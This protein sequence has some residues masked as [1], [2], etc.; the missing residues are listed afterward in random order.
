MNELVRVSLQDDVAVITI[1]NPPVNALSTP[2]A[3]SLA[4]AVRE[5][6]ANDSVRAIVVIGSGNTFVAG[7]DIRELAEI[8]AGQAPRLN[9]LSPLQTVED[10]RKPVVMAIHG[11]AL[12]GGLEAAMSGHYRLAIPSAQFAMPEVKLGLIPGA[13]G[14]QRLPRLV[15]PAR[16]VEMCLEGRSIGAPAALEYGLVDRIV[17]GDLLDEAVSF[18]RE[19]AHL[20]PPKTS[21]REGRLVSLEPGKLDAFRARI[22][23]ERPSKAPSAVLEAI[24]ASTELPFEAGCKRE[25][26]LFNDCLQSGESKALIHIFFGERA[27]AKIPALAITGK[28]FE[29][30][31]VAVIGAGTM[32]TGIAT[33]F[34]QAGIPVLLKELSD[35]ALS[36]GMANV[37]ANFERAVAKGRLTSEVGQSR[38]AGVRAQTDYCG[39]DEVDLAVEAVF[40]DLPVKQ[41]VMAELGKVVRADCILATNTSSLDVDAI[42]AG[43]GSLRRTI[44]L[45]FFSP[46]NVMRLLEVVPGTE[47]GPDVTAACMSLGKRLGKIAVC[48]RNRPGFI[49]NRVFR[50]YLREARLLVEEGALVEEVNDALVGFGM[51]MGPLAVDDLIGIDVSRHIEEEFSRSDRPGTRKSVLLEALYTSGNF[52]QKSGKGWAEYGSDRKPRPNPDID[53]LAAEAA[54][55]IGLNRRSITQ[56]EIV[57]RCVC[58]LVNEGA[59]ILEEGTAFRASDI[60]VVFVHGYSFPAWRG[61]PMFYADLN[62][63]DVVLAKIQMFERRFGS[64]LWAPAPLLVELARSRQSFSARDKA[65]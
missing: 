41:G 7:A 53:F 64:D 36:R 60:D 1:Y 46:A 35:E 8:A 40:E 58:S 25:E 27:A 23:R 30:R 11:A 19:I 44:G 10:S 3:E 2:V 4:S 28:R 65:G 26:E 12:G 21:E 18:A 38:L 50:P 13:G 32:G 59:R 54:S 62:G 52:G 15:G 51:G 63:I 39:F 17:E 24:Q 45:H 20:K 61:G 48:A 9:L 16:A 33:A 42:A 22:A 37:R 56:E 31:K 57:D 14:T 5:L 55:R 6:G 29:I 47:T 43:N 49:G 34:A